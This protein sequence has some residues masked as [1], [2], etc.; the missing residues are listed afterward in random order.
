MSLK[1]T[2]GRTHAEL[3]FTGGQIIGV[4]REVE[5]GAK[6]N[7]VCRRLGI[8][9]TTCYSW[10]S[11]FDDMQVPRRD[12]SAHSMRRLRLRRVVA[13]QALN[14]QVLKDVA[15]T[16]APR[17]SR[18]RRASRAD[19]PHSH[20]AAEDAPLRARL[21]ARGRAP[22][23]G[24]AVDVAT[25]SRAL[26]RH[27]QGGTRVSRRRARGAQAPPAQTLAATNIARAGAHSEQPLVDGLHVRS[28]RHRTRVS[29]LQRGR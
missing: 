7:A 20:T 16:S 19:S 27:S 8:T 10:K 2:G 12:D 18:A 3:R 13:D 15:G 23:L 5:S 4:L 29:P 28:A 1:P 11:K 14:I 6:P 17:V 24:A 21:Q 22:T 25:A 9:G 26:A